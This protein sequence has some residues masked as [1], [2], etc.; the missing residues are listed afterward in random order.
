MRVLNTLLGKTFKPPKAR[1]PDPYRKSR[2]Q[3]KQLAAQL[4]VEIE[5]L[6]PG[7]NVW[8]PKELMDTDDDEFKGDHYA[9]DWDGVLE[10]VKAYGA[11]V[12]SSK[13]RRHG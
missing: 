3:A 8:P 5:Q 9:D 1:Q 2:P 4:G 12:E 13:G 10:R 11:A 6:R 7:F